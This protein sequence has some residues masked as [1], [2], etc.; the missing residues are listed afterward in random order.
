[1]AKDLFGGLG[2]LSGTLGGLVS[3]LAK[4]G[5][6]PQDDP[7][8]K[9]INAQT[10][11]NDLNNQEAEVL[12]EIGRQAFAQNPAAWPQAAKLNLIRSN[13]TDAENKLNALKAEQEAAQREKEAAERAQ[14]AENSKRCCPSCG[15]AND[16]GI[17]FCQECGTKLGAAFCGTCGTQL[18]PGIRFCGS[19]GARTG[20]A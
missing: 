19:C 16:E 15:H 7:E 4:S 20:E 3:G 8:V 18:Q 10:D 12:V 17:N 6:A 11:L 5:F 1:M 14:E 9:L 2:N 13:I